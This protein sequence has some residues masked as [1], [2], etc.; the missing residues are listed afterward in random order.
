MTESP[1]DPSRIMQLGICFFG[2]RTP[3]T[4]VEL[5]EVGFDR[6]EIIVLASPSSATAADKPR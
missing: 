2:S 5:G 3:F 1:P 4:G 6:S